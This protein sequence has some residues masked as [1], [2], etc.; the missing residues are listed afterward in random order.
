MSAFAPAPAPAPVEANVEG[1]VRSRIPPSRR[2]KAAMMRVDHAGEFGATRIYEGQLAV[3]GPSG[4]GARDIAHMAEQEVAHLAWF[5]GALTR[6]RVRP[7]LLHPIWN[8][9]GFALGAVT[10]AISPEAAMACTAAVET[11]ID[12]HY[13]QQ[14]QALAGHDDEL[15]GAIAQFQADELAHRDHALAAG[16]ERAVGYPL[17]SA[18]IRAICR[19]AIRLS[20]RI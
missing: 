19:I 15:E 7:T 11:E 10:A 12:R 4:P 17:L 2:T 16:A 8:R 20:E 6:H 9:G 3:L 13:E 1:K 14:R 18:G 5:N